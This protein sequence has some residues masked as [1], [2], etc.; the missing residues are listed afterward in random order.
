MIK[1]NNCGT[2]NMDNA[3]NCFVC[4]NALQDYSSASVSAQY[5]NPAYLE[6][7]KKKPRAPIIAAVVAVAVILGIVVIVLFSLPSRTNSSSGSAPVTNSA[8]AEDGAVSQF[9]TINGSTYNNE[10]AGIHYTARSG[11][12]MIPLESIEAQTDENGRKFVDKDGFRWYYE[13]AAQKDDTEKI[14][15][16][17]I[18]DR[19]GQMSGLSIKEAR[20]K[21]MDSI[22]SELEANGNVT[23][24][25][26]S[27]SVEFGRIA[28]FYG[29]LEAGSQGYY[30]VALGKPTSDA[31]VLVVLQSAETF[32]GDNF[33][34][35]K[36]IG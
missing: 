5:S 31:A 25:Y 19:D 24:N 30:Q 3:V 11:W 21:A 28:Y 14:T 17:V 10:Y 36:L 22:A 33:R 9:G 32:D 27:G 2:E 1:C 26:D 12:D 6:A 4:G 8:S 35:F 7:E 16:Y 23:K 34:Y 29:D 20:M 15:V 18:K 13:M